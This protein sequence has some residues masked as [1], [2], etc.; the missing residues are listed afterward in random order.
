MN[1]SLT[2]EAEVLAEKTARAIAMFDHESQ[3]IARAVKLLEKGEQQP[4]GNKLKAT[5]QIALATRLCHMTLGGLGIGEAQVNE[6]ALD[7][8]ENLNGLAA[9]MRKPRKRKH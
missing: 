3:E 2:P 8:L 1:D 9:D 4:V 5:L 7:L 6:I